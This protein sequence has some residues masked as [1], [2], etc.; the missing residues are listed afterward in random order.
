M[1]WTQSSL[2]LTIRPALH[3][4]F[5]VPELVLEPLKVCVS[6]IGRSAWVSPKLAKLT[7]QLGANAI[8]RRARFS[9]QRLWNP[10]AYSNLI[11]PERQAS[12]TTDLLMHHDNLL[13]SS[14]SEAGSPNVLK[15]SFRAVLLLLAYLAAAGMWTC[16]AASN[17]SPY[18][19]LRCVYTRPGFGH[20]S[21]PGR[22]AKD[23]D[24]IG[25]S[26]VRRQ[27]P[28]NRKEQEHSFPECVSKGSRF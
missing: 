18:C 10:F 4:C 15:L 1:T 13:Q 20:L 14:D 12:K 17:S 23:A 26:L 6:Q 25:P 16:S 2:Q 5:F 21:L 24:S 27:E 11:S 7:Y 22:L 28:T 8:R 9:L 3:G 19:L